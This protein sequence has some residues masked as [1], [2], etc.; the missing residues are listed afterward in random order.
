VAART[1]YAFGKVLQGLDSTTS[2]MLTQLGQASLHSVRQ[3]LA[4]HG[5]KPRQL[6]V[7]DLLADRGG[8]GQRELGEV[9][10]IDHSV[11]V[12]MLNPLE[13]DGL[14]KRERNPQDRRRHVVTITMAGQRRLAAAQQTFHDVE[15]AFLAPL[16]DDQRAQLHSLLDILRQGHWEQAD[17]GD[18][19]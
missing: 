19:D 3:A 5:L 9:M 8:L 6:R 13:A 7:L 15:A 17:G 12:Q 1:P 18:C 2:L 11:L 4:A 14:V 10:A 16:T